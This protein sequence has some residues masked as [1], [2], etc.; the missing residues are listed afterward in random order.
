MHH[1]LP[2]ELIETGRCQLLAGRFEAALDQG[3]RACA[4]HVPRCTDG[5][6]AEAFLLQ[7]DVQ[8]SHE[9]A[10]RIGQRAVEIEDRNGRGD[11]PGM[12]G[13][14]GRVPAA[15]ENQSMGM[16]WCSWLIRSYR[17]E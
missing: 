9:V 16:I 1:E 14:E 2:V 3:P 8:G 13:H 10:C 12:N 11:L 6:G 5:E 15:G 17:M 4:D 7:N